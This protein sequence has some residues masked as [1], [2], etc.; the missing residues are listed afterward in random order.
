MRNLYS[1]LFL[2]F[3][4]LTITSCNKE[5]FTDELKDIQPGITFRA[6]KDNVEWEATYSYAYLSE[7]NNDISVSGVKQ[8][9][10]NHREELLNFSFNVDDIVVGEK[11]SGF[12][13]ELLYIIGGDGISASYSKSER[14]NSGN[15]KILKLDRENHLIEGVFEVQF[16]GMI[17]KNGLFSITYT[18]VE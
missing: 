17:F 4:T 18:D 8:D 15:I 9:S 10:I 13:S 11:Y 1:I 12:S 5:D 7:K 14:V 2:F 16:A 6:E 3:L